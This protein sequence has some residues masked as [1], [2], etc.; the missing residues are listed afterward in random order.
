MNSGAFG[1]IT[2]KDKNGKPRRAGG[3]TAVV[4]LGE[5]IEQIRGVSYQPADLRTSE[6]KDGVM[7]LRAN[8]IQD[9]KIVLNDV[10]Y[11]SIDKVNEK[12]YLRKGDILVCTSSGSRDLVGKAAFVADDMPCVFGAFCKVVRP[13]ADYPKYIGYFFQSPSYRQKISDASAGANINNIR[14]EHIDDLT[15]NIPPLDEQRKIT[16][17]LDK[18]SELAAKRRLQLDKLDELVKSRFVEMFGDPILNPKHWLVCDLGEYITFLT[19]GSR[20]WAKHFRDEGKY[21]ITIK[22]VKNCHIT[23]DNVQYVIPPDNAE[24]KRTKVKEGDLLIS[25]TADLGRTGVVTKEIAD[26][27]G[28]INQHLTCIRLNRDYVHPVYVAYFMESEAGKRQFQEKNQ[29]GVKAGLN[30]N[31]IN[32]LKFMLPPLNLQNEFIIFEKAVEETK[33]SIRRSLAALETLKKSKMQEFF[34]GAG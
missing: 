30:F 32:S 34:G 26:Y 19:S 21:F 28:Y 33:S 27:G 13:K 5:L 20:G 24:A 14:N 10:L 31:S 22:N 29:T 7:L 1:D 6:D 11:V 12:Q 15:I 18:I 25:I 17:L 3:K 23:L 2:N 9:G 8:N 4:R 16:A